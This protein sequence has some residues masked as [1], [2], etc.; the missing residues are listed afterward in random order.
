MELSVC[1]QLCRG[2]VPDVHEGRVRA[3]S[4]SVGSLRELR[5]TPPRREPLDQM[6]KVRRDRRITLIYKLMGLDLS[7]SALQVCRY[8]V[9]R[10]TPLSRLVVKS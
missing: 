7:D 9:I 3:A 8:L 6:C 5:H 1:C 2:W 10:E 4:V